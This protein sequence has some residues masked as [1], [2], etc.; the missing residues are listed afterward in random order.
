MIDMQ[1]RERTNRAYKDQT[2]DALFPGQLK[3]LLVGRTITKVEDVEG[4][5]GGPNNDAVTITFDNGSA[6]RI[7]AYSG[8]NIYATVANF[9]EE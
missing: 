4:R 8:G 9:V 3:R 7:D 6:L 1:W 2:E 5:P